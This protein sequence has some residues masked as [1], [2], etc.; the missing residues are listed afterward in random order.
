MDYIQKLDIPKELFSI[1]R[2]DVSSFWSKRHLYDKKIDKVFSAKSKAAK[3]ALI[4]Y[5]NDLNC[6]KSKVPIDTLL[7]KKYEGLLDKLNSVF[8][9]KGIS[10]K[11]SIHIKDDNS[12]NAGT[13]PTGLILINTGLIEKLD[14]MEIVAVLAHEMQHFVGLHTLNHIYA[15]NKNIRDNKMLAELGTG[16]VAGALAYTNIN[17]APYINQPQSQ[18]EQYVNSVVLASCAFNQAAYLATGDFVMSYSREQEIEADIAAYRFMQFIGED[19]QIWVNVL[20]KIGEE[21]KEN[22]TSKKNDGDH[23]SAKYRIEVLKYL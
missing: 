23:P 17:N 12:F 2:K 16:I 7:D 22:G 18:S 5:S 14:T 8:D 20:K 4:E 3:N 19:P 9:F 10:P 1:P 11:L 6:L 13:Y 21:E 15:V